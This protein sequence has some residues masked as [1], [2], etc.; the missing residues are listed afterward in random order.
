MLQANES[1]AFVH[2]LPTTP[3]SPSPTSS[4]AVLVRFPVVQ[5]TNQSTNQSITGQ[6]R[7]S[8]DNTSINQ[9]IDSL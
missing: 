6:D 3:N 2:E 9:S 7:V 8:D 4:D 1:N 5:S